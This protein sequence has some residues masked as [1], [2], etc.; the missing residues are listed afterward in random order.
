MSDPTTVVTRQE[1]ESLYDPEAVMAPVHAAL[2]VAVEHPPGVVRFLSR[3]A[4]LNAW[5]GSGVASLSGKIGRSRGI[6][7][8]LAEP[9][10]DLSDRSVLVAS[11]FF[12]A[13]RDEFDDRDTTHRDTHRCLAQACIKGAIEFCC[14]SAN[15]RALNDFL[16]QPLWLEGIGS[17]VANGYGVG[18]PDHAAALFRSMGYH[19]G[20]EILADGEFSEIDRAFKRECPGLVKH[21]SEN[22]FTI[23][24]QK[25]RGYAWIGLHSGEG[26]AKEVEH[27]ESATAGVRVALSLVSPKMRDECRHQIH[28]GI[29]SFVRDH[30]EFFGAVSQD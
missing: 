20:S 6:F 21:L 9:I 7:T 23:Y 29:G 14:R 4:N 24:G 10:F 16:A 17:R 22:E 1:I 2:K 3:Y 19:I 25:H 30:Q 28:L 18:T 13:A 11:Y 8:D 27:F 26:S 5:F 12:D 15:V